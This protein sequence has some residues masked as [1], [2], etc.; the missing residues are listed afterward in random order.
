MHAS[1]FGTHRRFR[2]RL[3][4]TALVGKWCIHTW[5][6]RHRERSC[7]PALCVTKNDRQTGDDSCA[8]TLGNDLRLRRGCSGP[9]VAPL[10]LAPRTAR[11]GGVPGGAR[12][13]PTVWF[14]VN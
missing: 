7:Y 13:L 9:T 1:G 5:L 6:R 3:E 4:V 12:V 11:T 10:V 2:H 8:V 14:A